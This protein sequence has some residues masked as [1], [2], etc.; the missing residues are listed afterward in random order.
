MDD[1]TNTRRELR[2]RKVDGETNERTNERAGCL[3]IRRALG[4]SRGGCDILSDYKLFLLL[5][6]LCTSLFYSCS[7][8]RCVA[9][10]EART[11]GDLSVTIQLNYAYSGRE[12]MP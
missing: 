2:R 11:I 7:S 5:L 1:D 12:R 4:V 10:H 6:G 9:E 3:S 8:A